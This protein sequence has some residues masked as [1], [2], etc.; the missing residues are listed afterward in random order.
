MLRVPYVKA[1]T[2]FTSE[3]NGSVVVPAVRRKVIT[4]LSPNASSVAGCG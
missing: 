2:I 4:P 1:P 3:P